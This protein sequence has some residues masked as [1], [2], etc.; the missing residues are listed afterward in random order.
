MKTSIVTNKLNTHYFITSTKLKLL[1]LLM[2]FLSSWGWGQ[3]VTIGS[4]TNATVSGN[5]N[6][7]DGSYNS[8]RYQVIYTA[9]ELTA[10]G[11]PANSEINGLGFS[12]SGDY[13]GGNLLGYKIRMGHTLE[14]N[15]AIHN[16]AVLTEVKNS[17]SYNPTVTAAGAFDMISFNTNF[18]WDGTSNIV[19]DICSD[20]SNPYTSPYGS[21]RIIKIGRAHV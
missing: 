13:G 10:A 11:M 20:G 1:T 16:T 2:V 6:P 14:V 4:G 7:I 5:S 17:F 19:I 21:V 15:S 9:S 12:I 8:F 3:T 18:T